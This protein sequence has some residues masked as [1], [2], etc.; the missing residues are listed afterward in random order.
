M[1]KDILDK[2]RIPLCSYFCL[3]NDQ[4]FFPSGCRWAAGVELSGRFRRAATVP[5]C[6]GGGA[7]SPTAGLL[8][9]DGGAVQLALW[10]FL[11]IIYPFSKE[12]VL[13]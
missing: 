8:Y 13:Q 11:K 9:G 3:H 1:Y 12:I 2:F 7:S 10:Y 5:C 4:S 6:P